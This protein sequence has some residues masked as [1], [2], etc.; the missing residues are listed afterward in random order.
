MYTYNCINISQ[1]VVLNR[2]FI[3]DIEFYDIETNRKE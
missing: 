2:V 1:T 3:I